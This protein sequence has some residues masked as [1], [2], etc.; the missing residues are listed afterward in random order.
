MPSGGRYKSDPAPDYVPLSGP[1]GVELTKHAQERCRHFF[2]YLFTIKALKICLVADTNKQIDYKNV[3]LVKASHQIDEGYKATQT[4]YV[5]WVK[6]DPKI[7]AQ[8]CTM[9][10]QVDAAHFCN[11]GVEG[12]FSTAMMMQSGRVAK[13]WTQLK[14]IMGNTRWLP[15][16]VNIGPDRKIDIMHGD[17][18]ISMLNSANKLLSVENIAVYLAEAYKRMTDYQQ[19]KA[20]QGY[21]GMVACAQSYLDF[22]S[23]AAYVA[24]LTASLVPGQKLRDIDKRQDFHMYISMILEFQNMCEDYKLDKADFIKTYF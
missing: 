13:L 7:V 19:K 23:G 1:V 15:K 16:Q 10:D 6:K 20:K 18:A 2:L 9:I 3:I 17:L 12:D 11:L 8:M 22:Y 21:L 14:N 4:D 24:Q 5:T